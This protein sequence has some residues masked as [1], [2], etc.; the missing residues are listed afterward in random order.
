MKKLVSAFAAFTMMLALPT[1]ALAAQF[2]S[3]SGTTVTAPGTG[4]RHLRFR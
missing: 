4:R 1:V 3:P 2:N